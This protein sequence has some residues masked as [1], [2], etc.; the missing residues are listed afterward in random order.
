MSAARGFVYQLEPVRSSRQ[1]ELDARSAELSDASAAITAQEAKAQAI[2]AGQHAAVLAWQ[3]SCGAGMQLGID[4]LTRMQA[5]SAELARQLQVSSQEMVV[6]EE[7]R[8]Q[9]V[10]QVWAAQRSLEAV[11]KHRLQSLS[12]YAQAGM[13]REF[14]AADNQWNTL[15]WRNALNEY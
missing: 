3:A 12:R 11:E 15:Q 8:S 4:V 7:R 13:N 10:D 2:R 5:Y 9:L 14:I 6:L 1:W